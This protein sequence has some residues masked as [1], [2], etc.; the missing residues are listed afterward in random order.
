VPPVALPIALA[1]VGVCSV[2]W[3][4]VYVAAVAEAGNPG[5]VGLNTGAS[6]ALINLGAVLCPVI[7]GSV[8]QFTHSWAWGWM[9]CSAVSLSGLVVIAFSR[10][11]PGRQASA[12]APFAGA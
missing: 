5:E 9:F 7:A 2:G 1:L 4:G 3:N 6:L 12:D 8:V 10:V 11:R